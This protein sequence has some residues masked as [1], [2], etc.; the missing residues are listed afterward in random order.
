MQEE[1]AEVRWDS[2]V[3]PRS[4]RELSGRGEGLEARS[5]T[6]R[7]LPRSTDLL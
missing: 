4:I 3:K 1:A 2:V 6:L 7:T 5:W